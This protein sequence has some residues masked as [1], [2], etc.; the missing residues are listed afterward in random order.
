MTERQITNVYLFQNG[1]VMTFDQFGEQMPDYQG[2]AEEVMP[3]IKAVYG[4][5]VVVTQWPSGKPWTY[6]LNGLE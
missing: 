4:G 5:P 3:K 2:R 6:D 1:M